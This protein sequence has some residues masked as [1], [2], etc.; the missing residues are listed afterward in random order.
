MKSRNNKIK[1]KAGKE[2]KCL[3]EY[4][5]LNYL[6]KTKYKITTC[7]TYLMICTT[8]FLINLEMEEE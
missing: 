8:F 1:V 6:I 3:E 4:L 2:R 5:I 7:V